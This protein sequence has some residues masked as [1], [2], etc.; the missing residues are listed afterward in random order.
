[1]NGVLSYYNL[2]KEHNSP[3]FNV[4]C[5]ALA[6]YF[7]RLA[8][9]ILRLP[10]FV[11]RMHALAATLNILLFCGGWV[12][13]PSFQPNFGPD[14][15][16][17]PV[18]GLN[19][20]YQIRSPISRA[21]V[22]RTEAFNNVTALIDA[23]WITFL[24]LDW[25][26]SLILLVNTLSLPTVV[27][28]TILKRHFCHPH[29]RHWTIQLINSPCHAHAWSTLDGHWLTSYSC[30]PWVFYLQ[31]FH[32]FAI[33]YQSHIAW[34]FKKCLEFLPQVTGFAACAHKSATRSEA[35]DLMQWTLTV[36]RRCFLFLFDKMV[37]AELVGW[38]RNVVH[39]LWSFP[40]VPQ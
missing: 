21:Q 2:N 3:G 24:H 18:F 26:K 9:V 38:S 28:I 22:L 34:F 23:V 16:S 19:P 10:I 14:P 35:W 8:V 39:F 1:M 36:L 25:R 32:R 4:F 37:L 17:Q 13:N 31:A 7:S 15:S 30:P 40:S 27:S 33:V 6:A 5:L 20:S 29:F 11:W 12:P